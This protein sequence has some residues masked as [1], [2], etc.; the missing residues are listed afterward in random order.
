MQ[1]DYT[2]NNLKFKKLQVGNTPTKYLLQFTDPTGCTVKVRFAVA[3]V[4]DS[5]FV[6]NHTLHTDL[7]IPYVSEVINERINK[8]LNKLESH[9][10]PPV[11][12]LKQPMRNRRLKRRWTSDL[13]D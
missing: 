2:G 1:T 6:S 8:H 5:W 3:T 4:R 11:E 12:T 10:D 9:P 7:N 13:Q